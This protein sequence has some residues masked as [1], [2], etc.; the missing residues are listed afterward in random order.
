M[1]PIDAQKDAVGRKKWP[2]PF[3]GLSSPCPIRLFYLKMKSR[4]RV[5]RIYIRISIK[6]PQLEDVDLIGEPDT[7]LYVKGP[8]IG[9][10]E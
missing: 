7:S 6:A 5:C 8:V 9:P 2:T 4:G 3:P 1:N 10:G